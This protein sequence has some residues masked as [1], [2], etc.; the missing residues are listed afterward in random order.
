VRHEDAG[1]KV[2]GRVTK[3]IMNFTEERTDTTTT[4]YMMYLAASEYTDD[5]RKQD[6]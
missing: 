2:V 4:S 5:E 3:D 6:G 1:V